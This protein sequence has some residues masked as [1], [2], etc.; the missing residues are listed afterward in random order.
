VQEIPNPWRGFDGRFLA[1][2]K[3]LRK[4][5][6]RQGVGVDVGVNPDGSYYLGWIDPKTKRPGTVQLVKD[7]DQIQ[8]PNAMYHVEFPNYRQ[9]IGKSGTRF[10]VTVNIADDT[11]KALKALGRVVRFAKLEA[12]E[13]ELVASGEERSGLEWRLPLAKLEEPWGDPIGINVAYLA[14]AIGSV[15]RSGFVRIDRGDASSPIHF[16]LGLESLAV[17]MPARI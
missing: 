8:E 7:G 13:D 17:V 16:G 9:V 12:I 15:L 11:L 1:R 6:M 14:D 10:D 5:P 2:P 3:D 4:L